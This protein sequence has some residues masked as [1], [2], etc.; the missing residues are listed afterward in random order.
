[1]HTVACMV[2]HIKCTCML[3]RV[4]ARVHTDTHTYMHIQAHTSSN[5]NN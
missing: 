5:N 1:M 4:C 3:M 2:T